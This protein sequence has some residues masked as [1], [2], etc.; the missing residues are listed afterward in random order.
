THLKEKKEYINDVVLEGHM[1]LIKEILLNQLVRKT[2][3][4]FGPLLEDGGWIEGVVLK[5]SSGNMVKLVDKNKFGVIREDAWRVRNQLTERA[6]SIDGNH[7]FLGGLRVQMAQA[8]GHAEL[9]T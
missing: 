4:P 6:R 7:S 9:G 5:D 8:L 2:A 1:M 3:S